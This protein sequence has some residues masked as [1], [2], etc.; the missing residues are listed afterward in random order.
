MPY[1]RSMVT[2]REPQAKTYLWRSVCH[3]GMTLML[4]FNSTVDLETLEPHIRNTL[5]KISVVYD[6]YL[7]IYSRKSVVLMFPNA[8]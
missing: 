8:L 5:Q 1:L 6:E 7:L 3:Y 4:K 2:L